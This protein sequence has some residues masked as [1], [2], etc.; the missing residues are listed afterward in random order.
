MLSVVCVP[1]L[2][3]ALGG[4]GSGG[5]RVMRE[6]RCFFSSLSFLFLSCL[7]LVL[8]ATPP[9]ASVCVFD[10]GELDPCPPPLPT[11]TPPSPQ[12]DTIRMVSSSAHPSLPPSP[13]PTFQKMLKKCK[14]NST[15]FIFSL[16][17]FFF[18]FTHT[19]TPTHPHTLSHTKDPVRVHPPPPPHPTVEAF[20]SHT[21]THTHTHATTF[22]IYETPSSPPPDIRSQQLPLPPSPPPPPF[23]PLVFFCLCDSFFS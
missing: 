9:P 4:G 2:S 18:L 22:E 12:Y 7:P 10:E 6:R 17:L 15:I 1:A 14:R 21:H 19:C 5:L 11:P 13:P 16:L 20:F 8:P 3:S 23:P